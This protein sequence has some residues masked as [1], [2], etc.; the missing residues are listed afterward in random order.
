MTGEIYAVAGGKGGVG[1]TTTAVFCGL[2]AHDAGHD[3]VV[4]DADLEMA[5]IAQLCGID[6]TGPTLHDVLA[7]EASLADTIT[8]GSTGLSVVPGDTSIDGYANAVPS[9]L[10]A[11]LSDL[12]TEF[13]YVFVDTG[14]GLT[15][16]GAIP[17]RLATKTV[18]VTTPLPV[19]VA[20]T[21]KT[22]ALTERLD[23]TVGGVVVTMAGDHGLSA[24][25]IAA[26]LGS[27]V[28]ATIPTDPAVT[29][30]LGADE[31]LSSVSGPAKTAY[32]TLLAE[33]FES[34]AQSGDDEPRE[35]DAAIEADGG[36]DGASDEAA[37]PQLA[38]L[39]APA[40]TVIPDAEEP[41]AETSVA[42]PLDAE[43]STEAATGTKPE[44][45]DPLDDERTQNS[46]P[47]TDEGDNSTGLFARLARLF[48]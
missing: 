2:L 47:E 5:N 15:H 40:E 25:E 48:G 30:A 27:P 23:G 22:A 12:T 4:V 42:A 1:K 39:T 41:T 14:A 9:Q 26:R 37:D 28:L 44:D 11:V 18:L 17:L 3:V 21:A 43:A 16:E 46:S 19:A 6:V 13:D 8:E 10:G 33:L 20:D 35:T 31:S 32:E 36:A 7:G 29:A 45:A 34:E 38:E 24:N